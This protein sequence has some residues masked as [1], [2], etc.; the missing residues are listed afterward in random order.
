MFKLI[1]LD[2]RLRFSLTSF[3]SPS[4]FVIGI[5]VLVKIHPELSFYRRLG[6]IEWHSWYNTNIIFQYAILFPWVLA[7]LNNADCPIPANGNRSELLRWIEIYEINRTQHCMN[8]RSKL[9]SNDPIS[10]LLGSHSLG[11]LSQ[12]LFQYTR[13]LLISPNIMSRFPNHIPD[14]LFSFPPQ[15]PLPLFPIFSLALLTQ[16]RQEYSLKLLH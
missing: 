3:E 15:F 11:N 8:P 4:L 14:F 7:T 16:P 2:C 6:T 12:P 13:P 10:L 5:G 1:L 9:L